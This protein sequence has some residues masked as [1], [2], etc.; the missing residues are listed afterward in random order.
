VH[1]LFG[2][3]AVS[4]WSRDS[5]VG[6]VTGHGI[7]G[8]GFESPQGQYVFFSAT[9]RQALGPTQTPIQLVLGVI[10]PGIK[11]L[12]READHLLSFNDEVK[13]GGAIPPFPHIS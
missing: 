8:W 9:S 6:V 7:D 5:S 2:V 1:H 10:F 13:N 4:I 3:S 11:L 12:G